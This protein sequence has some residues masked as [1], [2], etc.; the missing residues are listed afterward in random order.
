MHVVILIAHRI[1]QF[2]VNNAEQ[3]SVMCTHKNICQI[4]KINKKYLQLKHSYLMGWF[5]IF[6][7]VKE[8][9]YKRMITD[10]NR[11]FIA[12]FSQENASEM[13]SDKYE[14]KRKNTLI[15]I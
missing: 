4:Q 10:L 12:Y 2:S 13:N 3:F 14:V 5:V 8:T 7:N 1:E 6:K 11:K 9:L 15:Q